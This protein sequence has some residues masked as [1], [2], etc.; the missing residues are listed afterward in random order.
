MW[1]LRVVSADSGAAILDNSFEPM[2][3]VA[4]AAVL[5]EPPYREASRCLA[6]P[7]FVSMEKGHDL[8]VTEL[9]LCQEL[10]KEVRADVVHLDISFGG[11]LVEEISAT[12]LRG[13]ARGRMLKIL[14]KL[15][16]IATD[17]KR[18]YGLNVLAIGKESVPVR[19][20]EL[21]TGAHG[22]LH[23]CEL[24]LEKEREQILGLPFQCF[25]RFPECR[26][27][28][29][30]LVA[31]EHDVVGSAWDRRMILKNVQVVEMLNPG[32][33]GFRAL[34]VVPRGADS[35]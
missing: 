5:V 35:E 15:R 33:R 24:A 28:L 27:E 26:V 13:W 21:T 12:Q 1:S 11:I 3:I 9:E 22:V 2:Q 20:A 14:P 23:S 32:A 17:I 6:R 29:H 31:G 10:L 8:I 7:S 16:R 18:V 30:S 19:I 4:T 34:R 25:A